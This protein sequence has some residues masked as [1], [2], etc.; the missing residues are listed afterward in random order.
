MTQDLT[1]HTIIK[2]VAEF[3]EITVRDILGTSKKRI[4]SRPRMVAA[5]LARELLDMSY[6][7]IGDWMARNHTTILHSYRW[8]SDARDADSEVREELAMVEAYVRHKHTG[9]S[10]L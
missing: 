10:N 2:K 1:I 8:V 6:P 9:N 4:H 3:Y 7:E 5:Y